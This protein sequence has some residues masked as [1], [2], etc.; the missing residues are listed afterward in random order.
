M[1][2]NTAPKYDY[3]PSEG[4]E[5]I[6][7]TSLRVLEEF[8]I[9]FNQ[10]EAVDILER[11]GCE[12]DRD[13]LPAPLVKFPRGFVMEQIARAPSEFTIHARNPANTVVM[14]GNHM[15]LAPVYGPPNVQDLDKGRREATIEDFRN[16]VK[17]AQVVPDL[18]NAG[19]VVCEPNDEPQMTRHLDM[20]EAQLTLSDKTFMGNVVSAENANDSIEMASIVFG[21]RE[22][23]AKNPVLLALINVNS[24]R[25]YD[26]RMLDSLMVYAKAR[27]PLIITPFLLA[28]AM[29]PVA[30]AGT[31]VQQNAEALAGIALT[32]LVNPGTPVVYGSFLSN[33]DM[34]SGSPAFGTPESAAGL[35]V[36]AQLARKYK[37]PF[38]SGGGLTSSK[39]PD[40]QAM[41]EATM[42]FWPTFLACT[43]FVLHA[44]GWL[45]SGLVS[46]YEK[47]VMDVE[48]LRMMQVFLRGFSLDQEGLALDALEEI[49]PGG[50]F[51]GAA[52]TMRHFRQAF[53]RP[54]IADVQNYVRWEQKGAE[55]ADVRANRV[56]KK[57]LSEYE[58]PKMDE[59]IA[60]AL[61]EFVT[62]RKEEIQ[63]E[64][65]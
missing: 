37:L 32:Q 58:Q 23:M 2:T 48:I 14:G 41:W 27:Q 25:L 44:A 30:V 40:G 63:K 22:E 15:V 13:A 3:L 5:T 55:T 29:S 54:L 42:T 46:S 62:K 59:G 43:N 50:Y 57:W 53:Y 17:L 10:D 49:G 18:H 31:L 47:F 21:G 1:I 38:R 6:H 61:G 51:F 16:F 20:L 45:E 24:P 9:A 65:T 4:I 8:G 12:V 56:W 60:E 7:D 33:S 28:G 39:A 34:Q 35:F 26:T 11:A 19:G 64:T 36:S 52:H